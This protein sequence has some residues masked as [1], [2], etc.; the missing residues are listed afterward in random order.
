MNTN[1]IMAICAISMALV[2]ISASFAPGEILVLLSIPALYSATLLIQIMGAMY[3]AFAMI[4]WLAKD[5]LIGG[6]YGKPI[7][8]GNF[9]HFSISF[10][11]LIKTY[12]LF[13]HSLIFWLITVTYFIFSVILGYITFVSPVKSKDAEQ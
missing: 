10:L 11:A 5:N 13:S 1:L 7:A 4:N 12:D 2:G 9:A 3:F 6:I 8:L